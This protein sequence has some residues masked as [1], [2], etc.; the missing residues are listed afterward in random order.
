MIKT[1]KGGN[2]NYIEFNDH[3]FP[4]ENILCIER[5]YSWKQHN[6]N[7]KLWFSKVYLDGDLSFC[8]EESK[9]ENLKNIMQSHGI[10][11][12]GIDI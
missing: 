12:V 6:G 2:N 11:F 3:I 4:I 10:N 1:E 9:Y 7:E 5:Y 8:F